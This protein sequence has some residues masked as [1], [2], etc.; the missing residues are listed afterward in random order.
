M[1]STPWSATFVATTLAFAGLA[2]SP[3]VAAPAEG[4]GDGSAAAGGSVS[5]GGGSAA[6]DAKGDASAPK[7]DKPKKS[8]KDKGDKKQAAYVDD[9]E[10]PWIKRYAPT[11]NMAEI[12][13]FGGALIVSD[14]Q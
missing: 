3:A 4:A 1:P 5:L 9:A 10:R 8:K 6:A 2:P 13:V 7:P 11:R 12:G 14:N